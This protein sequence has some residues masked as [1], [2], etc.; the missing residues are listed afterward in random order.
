LEIVS[1]TIMVE[2][3]HQ[4]VATLA[5]LGDALGEDGMRAAQASWA[6]L[7]AEVEAKRQG[8]TCP[9]DPSFMG[10]WRSLV[11]TFAGGD[12]GI[13][14]AA[15][16]VPEHW[17]RGGVLRHGLLMDYVERAMPAGGK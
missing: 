9:S 1:R 3:S 8:G 5:T 6:E 13:M 17:S 7:I 2:P 16:D 4:G 11:E 15:A 12:P 10:R 14:G